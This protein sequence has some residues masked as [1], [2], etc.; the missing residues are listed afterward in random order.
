MTEEMTVW[1]LE[2]VA[3]HAAG[4]ILGVYRDPQS[5]KDS[6]LPAEEWTWDA[7]W[8]RWH[9][10]DGSLEIRKFRLQ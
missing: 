2:Y 9:N 7:K 6:I 4:D 8:D 3:D 10:Q 1:V 5:A